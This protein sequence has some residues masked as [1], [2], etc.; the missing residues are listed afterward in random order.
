MSVD[1]S[2]RRRFAELLK[3]EFSDVQF[4]ITTHDEVWA[5]QMRTA[6]L[7]TSSA[8]A[9]FYGWSVDSGPT[10]GVGDVW[11]GID[12]AIQ[13]GDISGAAAKLRRSLE[14]NLGDIAESIRSNVAY[15]SDASYDLGTFLTSVTARHKELLGRASDAAKAWGN[16]SQLQSV[17]QL[18]AERN[19]VISEQNG[20]QW[21]LNKLVHNN[22]WAN[23]TEG[24]I[25]PVLDASKEFLDLFK[26]SNPACGSWIT[27][28]GDTL[29][30][31]CQTY[32]LNLRK[33]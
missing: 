9:R 15:R 33:K 28:S 23:G 20:E 32:N 6:G 22:D 19:T 30:C 18:Q 8:M 17:Q 25:R 21:L 13:E 16:Q 26:C 27:F 10:Y 24:D 3:G 12:A 2:H 31:A 11:S 5:R 1:A 14:A 7:V 29:R 4:V